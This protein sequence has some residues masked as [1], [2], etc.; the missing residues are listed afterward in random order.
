MEVTR[1]VVMLGYGAEEYLE[2]ALDAVCADLAPGDEF[3]LVDNGIHHV[4]TRRSHWPRAV[5]VLEP[6]E[7][8]GFAGGCVYA[9]GHAGG[10][11]LIFLNSDAILRPGSL[12]P[13]AD[14]AARPDVGIAG[15]C[16]R[17]ADQPD[18]VNTVGNPL[19]FAGITWAGHCGE[20]A[21]SHTQ[22]GP[23]PVATGGFFA[24]R[25]DVWDRL[26]GFDP[27]FFAYHEDT[28]LSIRS[29]LA[30]L[31]VIFVPTAVADHH[32]EFGRNPLK[33]FLVERNRWVTV[34]TDYPA[35]VLRAVLPA[36]VALELPLL[37]QA[38]LQGWGA[39]KVRSWWWL[40][41]HMSALQTRRATVQR[42]VTA[43]PSVLADLMIARI[44]PPFLPPPPGMGV[45]N[46]VLATYWRLARRVAGLR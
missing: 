16:L 27:L 25:R 14:A 38:L 18:L 5:R 31:P 37:A 12:T 10:E 28:D 46:A 13:L 41:R 32:Y 21:S 44:E 20:P 6:R 19:H 39:Q 40:L 24:I 15:G 33:M 1:S 9:V 34:L 11:V 7:N 4:T 30:G 43:K 29:W 2:Q 8:T 35:P 22:G 45:L 36:A 3:L 23:V 42:G 26:G 17:L